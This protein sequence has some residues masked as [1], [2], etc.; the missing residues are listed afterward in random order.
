MVLEWQVVRIRRP[1]STGKARRATLLDQAT[2]FGNHGTCRKHPAPAETTMGSR[3][4]TCY[5]ELAKGPRSQQRD[6]GGHCWHGCAQA[7]GSCRHGTQD[8]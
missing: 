2:S 5:Q 1:T 4:A 7:E 8:Y 3:S 6:R